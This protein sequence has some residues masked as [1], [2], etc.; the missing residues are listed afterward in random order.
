MSNFKYSIMPSHYD[1]FICTACVELAR[2]NEQSLDDFHKHSKPTKE[3]DWLMDITD[4]QE[5]RIVEEIGVP[6]RCE[7]RD[8]KDHDLPIWEHDCEACSFIGTVYKE[9]K[10]I[11]MWVCL[12]EFRS[13]I[14]RYSSEPSDNDCH[15]ERLDWAIRSLTGLDMSKPDEDD[16]YRKWIIDNR[17]E[18]KS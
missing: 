11:D 12:G 6:M 16:R 15:A 13:I 2:E 4:K 8:C 18:N 14:F 10:P 3:K 17:K 5:R 9:G 1:E 7:H